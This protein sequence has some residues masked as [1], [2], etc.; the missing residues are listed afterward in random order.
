MKP[1]IKVAEA[2]TPGDSHLVLLQRDEEMVI[3]V[4]GKQ[5][6]SS[7]MHASEEAMATFGCEGLMQAKQPCVLIGGLGMGFTLR[8]TLDLV[9][10]NATVL[11][12]ELVPTLVEWNRGPLSALAKH[13]TKDPRVEV[14]IEDVAQTIK[15]SPGGF[16]AVLLDVDNGPSALTDRRNDKLYGKVSLVHIQNALRPGGKLVVWSVDEDPSFEKRLEECDFTVRKKRVPGRVVDGKAARNSPWH[17]LFIATPVAQRS[18]DEKKRP[19]W[20]RRD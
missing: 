9:P 11:V 17:V 16:N 6:M 5:L 12:S 19:P 2:T 13:P 10:R 15:R 8:A 4:D 20:A 7:R 1:W 14:L 18:P 3:S